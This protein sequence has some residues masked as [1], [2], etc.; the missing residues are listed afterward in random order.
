MQDK[1]RLA[2][3]LAILLVG[4]LAGLALG[5]LCAPHSGVEMRKKLSNE[6]EIA[7]EKLLEKGEEAWARLRS[8]D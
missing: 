5:F 3:V 7:K 4:G 8:Q 1:G 6:A 2:A